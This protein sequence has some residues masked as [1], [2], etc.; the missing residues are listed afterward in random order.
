MAG[1]SGFFTLI[2][3]REEPDLQGALSRFETMASNP[4]L[5]ACWKTAAPSS[6]AISLNTMPAVEPASSLANFALRSPRSSGRRSFPVDLQQVERMEVRVRC[7][8]LA[9]ERV[10]QGDA[11][12]AGHAASHPG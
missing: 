1:L 10:E 7:H 9:M 12:R 11:I 2:Q 3:S 6:S 4:N 8:T 5:Q